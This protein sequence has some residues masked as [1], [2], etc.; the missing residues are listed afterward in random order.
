M[1]SARPNST[2]SKPPHRLLLRAHLPAVAD[3][4]RGRHTKLYK[5]LEHRREVV[6]ELLLVLGVLLDRLAER[7]VLDECHVG[8]ATS[9]LERYLVMTHE[10][11]W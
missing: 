7:L 5:L 4:L 8:A 6:K 10:W 1:R 2:D 11:G 9:I 3:E